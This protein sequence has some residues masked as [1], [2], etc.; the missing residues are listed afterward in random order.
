MSD[1]LDRTSSSALIFRELFMRLTWIQ[2]STEFSSLS[3]SFE[4]RPALN[5][6]INLA[7]ISGRTNFPIGRR[8]R[9]DTRRK[10][11]ER[12]YRF[13]PELC[14]CTSDFRGGR[15][16]E[17]RGRAHA[18]RANLLT[19]PR[20]VIRSERTNYPPLCTRAT[21]T[22]LSLSF[23]LSVPSFFGFADN[24]APR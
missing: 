22:D 10:E 5:G 11:E 6:N 9:C 7:R 13:A 16:R 3:T 4:T 20:R 15:I 8:M 23:S 1:H 21:P 14:T 12:R 2:I 24:T 18:I 17:S 19:R